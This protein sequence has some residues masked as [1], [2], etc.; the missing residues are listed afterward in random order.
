MS[1]RVLELHKCGSAK[2]MKVKKG[3]GGWEEKGHST[4]EALAQVGR[5]ELVEE[6]KKWVCPATD[7]ELWRG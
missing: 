4:S 7:I 5:L 1:V 2:E 6:C 3:A